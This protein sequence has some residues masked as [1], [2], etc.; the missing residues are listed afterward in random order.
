MG[1]QRSRHFY[2]ISYNT[3]KICSIE[4]NR[5]S[6]VYIWTNNREILIEPFCWEIQ[7]KIPCKKKE[8]E[9]ETLRSPFY[10]RIPTIRRINRN[11]VLHNGTKFKQL[12]TSL[13]QIP[14]FV[15]SRNSF[16]SFPLPDFHRGG[17]RT[18]IASMDAYGGIRNCSSILPFD[19]THNHNAPRNEKSRNN[20][21][22]NSGGSKKKP[23]ALI[24][25]L[26]H[27]PPPPSFSRSTGNLPSPPLDT[28]LRPRDCR[29]G[30]V[31]RGSRSA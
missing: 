5:V 16:H 8:E 19:I 13:N 15:I 3:R 10:N 20:E 25:Q 12:P 30:R 2:S 23:G 31:S 11:S 9:K 26:H 27:S 14:A 1:I 7:Y 29:A 22:R 17:V 28:I 18:S 24:A 21:A 6:G 4:W